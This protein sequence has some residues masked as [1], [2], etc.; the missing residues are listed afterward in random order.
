ME[1]NGQLCIL[2]FWIGNIHTSSAIF[3]WDL[4]RQYIPALRFFFD[5]DLYRQYIPALRFLWLGSLSAIYTSSAIFFIGIFTAIY[6]SSA[7]W[8]F[9]CPCVLIFASCLRS[10]IHVISFL[11][12]AWLVSGNSRLSQSLVIF[13]YTVR[14]YQLPDF[15]F[16]SPILSAFRVWSSFYT[17]FAFISFQISASRGM[18]T[19]VWICNVPDCAK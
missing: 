12:D 18:Y 7:I 19:A 13:L 11:P 6:T 1:I 16:Q 8:F 15:S 3:D 14:F 10:D 9:C 5:W 17:Q 4:Y 2:L